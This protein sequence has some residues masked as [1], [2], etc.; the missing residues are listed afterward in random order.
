MNRRVATTSECSGGRP[1][2]ARDSFGP[3]Y[4]LERVTL[5]VSPQLREDVG[6]WDTGSNGDDDAE[7]AEKKR[8]YRLMPR[9]PTT[10]SDT[11]VSVS[12]LD[13][14]RRVRPVAGRASAAYL[15]PCLDPAAE[16]SLDIQHNT[17]V[18][19]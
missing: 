4:P 3:F 14:M 17:P 7:K 10:K 13:R 16:Y 19:L 5:D 11:C 18:N 9:A 8:M 1:R 15:S 12:F 2:F 6:V